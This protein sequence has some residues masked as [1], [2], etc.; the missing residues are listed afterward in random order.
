[1]VWRGDLTS[2]NVEGMVHSNVGCTWTCD[3]YCSLS[4]AG[5]DERSVV[6]LRAPDLHV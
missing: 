2:V 6:N 3:L 4:D 1:M 5:E